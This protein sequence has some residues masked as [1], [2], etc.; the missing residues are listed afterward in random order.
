MQKKSLL[1]ILNFALLVFPA[2]AAQSNMAGNSN[3]QSRNSADDDNVFRRIEGC[4]AY[5]GVSYVLAVVSNG[6]KQYRVVGGDVDALH[7]KVGHT[8]EIDGPTGRNNP[9]AMIE[10]WDQREAT[11]GVG[12]YTITAAQVRDVT[13]NCS[14][15]GFEYPVSHVHMD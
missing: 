1:L 15:S 9:Q 11:T 13:S 12:W 4:L 6:P 8:V 14:Y 5:N 10:N 3:S 7:G 2:L